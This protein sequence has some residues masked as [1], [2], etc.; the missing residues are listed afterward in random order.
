MKNKKIEKLLHSIKRFWYKRQRH[1]PFYAIAF[2][3]FR[4]LYNDGYK[5]IPMDYNTAKEYAGIFGGKVID[6]F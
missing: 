3:K 1:T 4:V 5:S 6:N 2:G